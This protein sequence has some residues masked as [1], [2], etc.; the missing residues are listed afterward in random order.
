MLAVKPNGHMYVYVKQPENNVKRCNVMFA[1]VEKLL[2]VSMPGP[3][4]V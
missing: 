1:A 2:S 3:V 4:I